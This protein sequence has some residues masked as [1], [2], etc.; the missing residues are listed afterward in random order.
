MDNLPTVIMEAMAAGLPVISTNVAAV[1]EMIVDGETGF[2]V[3]EEDS[4]ALAQK[5][6]FLVDNPEV[7]RAMG[8]RGRERCRELFDSNRTSNALCE[9]LT[10][11]GA[12][13]GRRADVHY[14][15]RSAA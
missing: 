7:A 15:S 5:M 13:P 9:V 6:T 11:H 12:L 3:A 4:A 1:S 2:V 14:F 10:S 8:M